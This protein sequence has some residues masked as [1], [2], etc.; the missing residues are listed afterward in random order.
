MH[1]TPQ[2]LDVRPLQAADTPAMLQLFRAIFGHEMAPAFH[3]WKY[4]EGAGCALGVFRGGELVAHY[5]GVG[6]DICYFGKPARAVQIV[7][8][9]VKPAARQS[10]RKG[11]PFYLAG[12]AFLEQYIGYKQPYLLGYGF[13]SDRHM[14]LAAHMKFYAPVGRM[15]ELRWPVPATAKA[16]GWLHKVTVVSAA[17]IVDLAPVL[18]ALWQSL[19]QSL[20]Q[21]IVVNKDAAHIARRYLQHPDKTYKVCL[22]SHRLSGKPLGLIVLKQ[23]P[24][25]QNVSAAQTAPSAPDAS[26]RSN[27]PSAS[28]A[29]NVPGVPDASRKMVLMDYVGA[30]NKLPALLKLALHEASRSGC[31]ELST[32][33]SATFVDKFRKASTTPVDATALP[34]TTPANIWTAGPQPEQL[35]NRWWLLP[36]DTDFL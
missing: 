31:S 8:V 34:I 19:Q 11:S 17:N 7:D 18:D 9:M 16:P 13:P 36:G 30:L 10:V 3:A 23:E 21:H 20:Q 4:R 12:S 1:T 14:A 28:S 5:G 15:W 6:A 26:N 25:E 24:Q 29:S 32:W 22:L 35:Q 33:C 2:P 27:V